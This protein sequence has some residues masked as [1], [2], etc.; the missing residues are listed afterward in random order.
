MHWLQAIDCYG[1][2]TSHRQCKLAMTHIAESPIP[3]FVAL[4]VSRAVKMVCYPYITR[5]KNVLVHGVS[6]VLEH[7]GSCNN[8]LPRM[9][10]KA[11]FFLSLV[12]RELS[13]ESNRGSYNRLQPYI[14]RV[15]WSVLQLCVIQPY[16]GP[17]EYHYSPSLTVY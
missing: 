3:C 5:F 8:S 9:L 2:C 13:H 16:P 17:C 10:D 6:Q 11:C 14:S 12:F 15:G 4:S 1:V 7:G